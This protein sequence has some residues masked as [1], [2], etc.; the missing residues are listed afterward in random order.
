[1]FL[2]NVQSVEVSTQLT[3]AAVICVHSGKQVAPVS[4]TG[5][6]ST[7]LTVRVLQ[8]EVTRLTSNE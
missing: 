2:L 5:G 7:A 6:T 4:T 3:N 1:M 8:I